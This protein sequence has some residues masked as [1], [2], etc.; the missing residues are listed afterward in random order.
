MANPLVARLLIPAAAGLVLSCSAPAPTAST[1]GAPRSFDRALV[2]KGAQLAAIGNCVN[3]HTAQGGKPYAG[4][5][6]LKTPFGTVH[7]TN[8]TPDP[9]TGIGRWSEADFSRALRE[10]LDPQ[11][12]HY[13]PAFPYEYFTRLSD[14]DVRA[15][16]A[17]FMTREPVNAAEP[18]NM[19]IAPRF[20]V[21]F[22]KSR[23]FE[24]GR[25]RPDTGRDAQWNRG[26]YLVG[27]LAHCSACHTPRDKL[28]GEKKGEHMSGGEVGGWHAP[29]LN[30]RSP[31]PVPWNADSLTEYLGRGLTDGHA[32][33]AGPMEGVVDNLGRV[34]REEVRAIAAY[35]AGLDS[36]SRL[37]RE[38][39]LRNALAPSP[40]RDSD[41]AAANGAVIYAGACADCHD[42][43]RDKEGGALQLPLAIALCLPTPANLIHI[44][45]DGIL[46][47]EHEAQ[48]W[49]P[50]FATALTEEQIADLAVYLRTLTDKPAW[51]DV[52]AEVRK[53]SQG[54][55]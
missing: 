47:R 8:I 23:Y 55:Q 43:G 14:D 32:I 15:L 37:E 10:G 33:A 44:T 52:R 13:Y 38:K 36:R 29:A 22:W 3:C 51:Q 9:D 30:D 34:P 39:H 2:A 1:Q 4:G 5:F 54:R 21:A 40:R 17:F 20:A 49:M 45:R 41:R 18:V 35:T 46:P 48:P 28:G 42:R 26:A 16:Y 27:A 53:L 7:G 24:P 11:G 19:M 6:P 12:R 50:E 25:F 31:S